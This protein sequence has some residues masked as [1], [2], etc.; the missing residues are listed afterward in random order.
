MK[1]KGIGRKLAVMPAALLII[2]LSAAVLAPDA[3]A[4][5]DYSQQY[6]FTLLEAPRG[7]NEVRVR[8]GETFT[9]ELTLSRTDTI[10]AAMEV[11]SLQDELQYSTGYLRVDHVET[12]AEGITDGSINMSNGIDRRV[13]IILHSRTN[14]D[15]TGFVPFEYS[16]GEILVR[17][18]F[19]AIK[20]GATEIIQTS[21]I[22]IKYNGADIHPSTSNNVAVTIG[23]GGGPAVNGIVTFIEFNEYNGAPAGYKVM[24]LSL[25]S[26][27]IAGAVYLFDDAAM[28]WSDR[29]P[30]SGGAALDESSALPDDAA[31]G[32]VNLGGAAFGSAASGV[33]LSNGA[34]L[35][36]AV[37]DGAFVFFVRES[38]TASEALSRV[39]MTAGANVSITYS[40]DIN[41]S[42]AT[43]AAD[44]QVPMALYTGSLRYLDD[45]TFT[46]LSMLMRLEADVN[47][48]GR[49]NMQDVQ[50]IQN[51]VLGL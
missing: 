14:S 40:G 32:G 13:L 31:V 46:S 50:I 49:V 25:T 44:S 42:G 12:V 34:A 16:P 5:V 28:Y 36:G 4:A 8:S 22:I 39:T 41:R 29:Y 45:N 38:M 43:N 20:D 37:S 33:T 6:A 47:G 15:G 11:I 7:G 18:T 35:E 48:N 3:L 9:L 10:G 51:M 17:V 19:T 21:H 1:T 24:L 27:R 26:A 2:I 30:P 23:S